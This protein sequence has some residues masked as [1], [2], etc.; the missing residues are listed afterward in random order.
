MTTI[1][2]PI[3]KKL[4]FEVFKR[5]SFT[6]QYCGST[7]PSVILHVDH[8]H[9][10]ADGGCNNIDN[11]I[12]ACLPCN[13]GKSA[14]PLTSIPKNLKDKC[15]E[16]AEREA[17]IR[18][19]N[20]I[21][22]ARANRIEEDAWKVAAAIEGLDYVESF[23]RADFESIKRF[24]DRLPTAEVI[25]AGHT[26]CAKGLRSSNRTFKYFCGICW[27]KVREE[28]DGSR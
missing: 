17:Q 2:K 26:A 14:T 7:P 25:A 9:P 5:D 15:A 10:V 3:S 12:T 1:R 4:R 27:A 8:I 22:T 18:G 20:E 28:E 13:L 16:V 21:L 6:C 19:Y 11:L 23:N 24:I